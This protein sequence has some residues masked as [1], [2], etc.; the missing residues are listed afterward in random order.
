MT[1]ITDA[2]NFFRNQQK[3]FSENRK[4]K[5]SLVKNFRQNVVVQNDSPIFP[6]IYK[7]K[8][9]DEINKILI[10]SY[11]EIEEELTKTTEIELDVDEV[12]QLIADDKFTNE[13]ILNVLKKCPPDE[14]PPTTYKFDELLFASKCEPDFD[15]KEKIEDPDI[16]I[17]EEEE[18]D[19]PEPE[20]DLDNALNE[21]D[22]LKQELQEPKKF[23]IYVNKSGIVTFLNNNKTL[24]NNDIIATI[25]TEDVIINIENFE[26]TEF[27]VDENTKI[28]KGDLL[29]EGIEVGESQ[30][31]KEIENS[32][33]NLI[34]SRKL[35]KLQSEKDD[36]KIEQYTWKLLVESFENI[37]GLIRKYEVGELEFDRQER[38]RLDDIEEYFIRLFEQIETWNNQ[39]GV[40][41]DFISRLRIDRINDFEWEFNFFKDIKD[42]RVYS[43][44]VRTQEL[45]GLYWT[46]IDNYIN[47]IKNI[48]T[49]LDYQNN[50]EKINENKEQAIDRDLQRVKNNLS[51]IENSIA[52]LMYNSSSS[53][54]NQQF[55]A[56]LN[57]F[58]GILDEP[59]QKY[60]EKLT[61]INDKIN[62]LN[63][64]IEEIKNEIEQTDEFQNIPYSI[65][66][67]ND[68]E[69]RVYFLPHKVEDE[70]PQ[71]TNMDYW[72]DFCNYA[73]LINLIPT[74]WPI[75]LLIPSPSG[76]LRIPMPIFWRPF[77]VITTSKGLLVN[78]IAICGLA[79]APW[80]CFINS[81]NINFGPIRS[82]SS[83]FI[84]GLRPMKK[85]KD[86]HGSKLIPL[87]PTINVNG[88]TID[89]DPELSKTLPYI[90]DDYPSKER[91][92][93]T[94]LPYIRFLGEWCDAGKRSQGFF[95]R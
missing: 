44:A 69:I 71:L 38:Q 29:C 10:D 12:N 1:L 2:I 13:E 41:N 3:Q 91:L 5:A 36:L 64:E 94:N 28:K 42:G 30:I 75:G 16:S 19:E 53:N 43:S 66:E 45:R 92:E 35:E 82:Q 57:Y 77:K 37:F 50:L 11:P 15:I 76:I 47:Q 32:K 61:E 74:Y 7:D 65:R 48:P 18:I 33:N 59:H 90:Q 88:Y 54:R 26:I 58:G 52:M 86:N 17:E 40:N 78:G 49:D 87:D 84:I 67:L 51:N 95:E 23:K 70:E 63:N 93:L 85:I 80:T 73:S 68:E 89:V 62:Q 21:I 56:N 81:S 60:N 55:T 20:L 9:I 27:L 31:N 8:S 46:I 39:F 4:Q 22:N 72:G 6:S 79:I 25:N 83:W 14:D 24:T 34:K